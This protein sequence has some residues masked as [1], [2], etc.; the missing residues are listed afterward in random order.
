MLK[1]HSFLNVIILALFLCTLCLSQS[2]HAQRSCGLW[3]NEVPLVADTAANTLYAT[4]EPGITHTLKGTLRWDES[5]Y[6]S[7][8]LNDQVLE[9]GKQNNLVVA[10]WANNAPNTLTVENGESRQWTIIFSTLP[11]VVIDCPLNEMTANYSIT[12]G[13]ENHTKKYPGYISVIDARCRTR[14]KDTHVEGMACFSSDINIRLRGA[15][16][17]SK[18]KKNFNI[19]L[20]KN[21]ESQDVHLL[22]YRKD[23]DWILASEYIDYSRMRNRV[24][25]DLWNSVD[26]L[27]YA[28]DNDYQCNGTQGEFV[29]AFVNGS[30]YG[31]MCFTDKIDRKKLNLKKTKEATDTTP[32]EIRGLVWKANWEC[33]ETYLSSYS[34]RPAN[35]SFLWPYIESKKSYGWEQKYPED[36]PTQA[37]FDPICDVIDFLGI[38][39]KEFSSTY[40]DKLYENNVIDFILFIQVFQL[41]DNQ[42]KNYYLSVRN[43]SKEQKFLFTLWDLD[44]SLGRYAGGDETGS[45]PKQMAWGEKLGYHHLI[46][47]FKSKNLRPSDFATKM[48]NRWQYLSKHQLSLRNI[49]ALMEHYADLFT[50]SGAWEREKA[51]WLSSYPKSK[52]IAETPQQEVDFMMDFLTANYAVFNDV[53]AS[54]NWTHSEYN[55]Q[56]YVKEH[57]PAALYVIGP[58]ITSTH[59]DNTV[60]LQGSVHQEPVDG[61]TAINYKDT[62]MTVI[63][64]DIDHEYDIRSIKEVRTQHTDIYPTPAFLPGRVKQTLKFDTRYAPID[65]TTIDRP[66]AFE[67]QRTVQVLFDSEKAYVKGNLDG[68]T[69]YVDT[70]SVTFT[71]DLEGVELIISGRSDVGRINIESQHP[72]KIATT[73]GGTLLS[74]INANCDLVIN[75]PYTLN[76]YN[77]EFDGKCIMSTGD[78]TFEN[79]NLIFLM[80]SSGTLTDASFNTNPTLGARA[81][82]AKN[83]HVNEGN[84]L[85]K[86]IGHHGAV[87][88][89][90]SQKIYIS[91]GTSCIATYDDPLKAGS[92]IEVTGG[93]TV[94]SSLTNDG[95]DTKGD[96]FMKGG[97]LY[98]CSPEG[99]EAAF[100]VNHFYC[101]GGTVVGVGFKSDQP[102]SSKSSQAFIRLYKS[103]DVKEYLSIVDAEGN[104][105]EIIMTP[106]YS[107]TTVLYSSPALQKGATYTLLTGDTYDDLHEL[108]TFAAE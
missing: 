56:Q 77:E 78:I 22:G 15:T 105:V 62:L 27:P 44:G 74:S 45:D 79:G 28:K 69:A 26:D 52:K 94:T 80:T 39:Q 75:T 72:W 20:T 33:G 35:D 83:I 55:E 85:I 46:H 95:L 1:R 36:S 82:M 93:N 100:D 3:L 4:I 19:E 60:I 31:L 65:E 86:T 14:K 47:R 106:A 89:A 68:I 64:D 25:M 97:V 11:F 18:P 32:E 84:I 108:T 96:L 92:A 30:Y 38:S 88:M 40:T 21:G 59:E 34:E 71:T 103:K 2:A 90:A 50:T 61:I 76:F 10:E 81:V 51:R 43:N 101:D 49:R 48:N 16:S 99:A 104:Q 58:D 107:T 7:I 73:A 54:A 24:I 63:R 12:K 42:K 37:F 23:D 53:M 8:R 29:E 70:T 66:T 5:L 98:C 87:G 102:I 13:D 91:G 9:N 41:L 57:T 6:C 17:G 67:T